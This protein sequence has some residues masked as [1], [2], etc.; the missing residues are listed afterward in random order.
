MTEFVKTMTPSVSVFERRDGAIEVQSNL[1]LKPTEQSLP[2]IFDKTANRYPDRLF[3]RDKLTSDGSWRSITYLEARRAA[4]GLAQ[5]LI[6][7]GL[8]F[9]DSVAYLSA[10][11]IEHAIAAIGVQRSGA[12]IAPI[13]VAYSL[14]SNDFAKLKSC[15]NSSGARYA[16]VD[17]ASLY[18]KAIAALAPLGVQF[19][20]VH[21]EVPGIDVIPFSE[22]ISTEPTAEVKQRMEQI[23]PETTARIMY[24]SGS[25][26]SPKAVPQ[27]QANLTLAVA[28]CETINILD[29]GDEA[30]QFL[31][32]MPFSHIMA[33][34]YNFNNMIRCGGTISID[35]GKPTPQLFG[36]TIENLRGLSPHCFLTVPIGFEMLCDAL[37]EDDTLAEG[38]FRKLRW[39]GFGGAVLREEVKNRL[40]ALSRK[41]RGED[42]PIF[43][44]YGATEYMLGAMK[45][46][47][48]GRTDVIGL[49]LPGGDLLLKPNGESYELWIKSPALMPR[50]GYLQNPESSKKLF[51]A[52]GYF[53][54]GDAVAFADPRDPEQGLEF[55]GRIADDFKLSSGTFVS[56]KSLRE[57]LLAACEPLVS[58]VVFC[59]LNQKWVACL[60]WPKPVDR[61]VD[62]E[63]RSKIENRID[64]FNKKQTG[65]S[66]RI[67]TAIVSSTPLSFDQNEVTDKGNV[68]ANA[69]RARRAADIE[70]LFE[71]PN[72]EGVLHFP[73][74]TGVRIK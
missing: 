66:R 50:S 27:P 7:K 62:D 16:I 65:S 41:Y 40:L 18:A 6:D 9:G 44:F 10:P 2:H 69:V 25:T 67:G 4:N 68:S 3:V 61:A 1:T 21:G 49:P 8:S 29:F 51:D 35:D 28:Q 22:I 59:G 73:E 19:I 24:T 15:I 17:D 47:H 20:G 46:W 13:S 26:G 43:A 33:G 64:A 34:N 57:D 45:Y 36:K 39:V 53:N 30:V 54:T 42:V 63:L 31:E 55:V 11:S 32:A 5:W 74:V 71:N 48:G 56:V 38:F 70:T 52:E 14:L 58:E 37:E 23:T 12:A 60:L 72:G